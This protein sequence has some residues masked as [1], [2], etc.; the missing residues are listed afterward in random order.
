MVGAHP[1]VAALPW[2]SIG[3]RKPGVPL[4]SAPQCGSVLIGC[5]RSLTDGKN[6]TTRWGYDQFGR[7]TNKLDQAGTEILRYQYDPESRLTNRWSK[8]KLNTKYAYDPVGNLTN[9]DYNSSTDVRF[10]FDLLNRMTNMVDAAGTTVFR[11]TAGNQL[12][13]ED[14]PFTSDTVTNTYVNRLRVALA[15]QQPT[16]FWTN[17]FGYDPAKRL[18]NVAMS[19]GSFGYTYPS[20]LASLL[21]IK[22]LLPN[23]SY[24]TNM[25]DSDSRLAGTYLKNSGNSVLDSY[26]Y[27]Y[28]PASER[29]NLTRAD[30]RTPDIEVFENVRFLPQDASRMA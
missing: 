8:E 11:W 4:R 26:V 15:L 3:T 9:I 20:G 10:G 16:G 18:T 29:T 14:G 17:G 27:A 5:L 25:Y 21:P 28:D 30:S 1:I 6:Q 22:L 23:T 13:T 7:V 24:I 2:L 12:L 19:A